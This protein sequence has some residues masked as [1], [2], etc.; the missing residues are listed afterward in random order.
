MEEWKDIEGFPGYR[1]S[2]CGRVYS[3]KLMR[4]LEIP[5]SNSKDGYLRIGLWVN[6]ERW[7]HAV[8]RL[9]A[10][11]F[12][13]NPEM[14]PTVNHKDRNRHNNHSSNLEWHTV[15]EQNAHRNLTYKGTKG[16]HTKPVVLIKDG[17][18]YSFEQTSHARRTLKL[19]GH[20]WNKLLSG[21]II[22][23][24]KIKNIFL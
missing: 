2:S 10:L 24:Y 18:E 3:K 16:I 20:N 9:V 4:C 6:N 14:K 15:A 13:P 5:E 17:V 22:Y 7:T 21:E 8:H 12:I 11:H 19:S 1:I 23:G